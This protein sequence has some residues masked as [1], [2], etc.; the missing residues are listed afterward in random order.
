MEEKSSGNEKKIAKLV[1]KPLRYLVAKIFGTLF[2]IIALSCA[3]YFGHKALWR[4]HIE[5]KSKLVEEQLSRCAELVTIKNRYS[6]IVSIKKSAA[7]GLAK[8][9]SIIKFNAI[10]RVGIYDIHEAKFSISENGKELRVIL[11]KAEILGNDIIHQEVFDEKRSIFIPITAKEIFAS[12]DEARNE[13]L[14]AVLSNG[15]LEDANEQARNTV[16]AMLGNLRFS[17]VVVE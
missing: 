4:T 9:Y 5:K 7:L 3:A 10:I 12:I 17:T 13:M 16:R 14:E 8:A 6:E 1:T 11:P 2:L 15:I